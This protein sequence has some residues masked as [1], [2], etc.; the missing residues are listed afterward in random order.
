[1]ACWALFQRIRTKTAEPLQLNLNR[2][3]FKATTAPPLPHPSPAIEIQAPSESGDFILDANGKFHHCDAL[4]FDPA[5]Q[6]LRGNSSAGS[7]SLTITSGGGGV[8]SPHGYIRG[9]ASLSR[10]A[11]PDST[12][13]LPNPT[14]PA[15]KGVCDRTR[16]CKRG[17]QASKC[18]GERGKEGERERES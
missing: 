17:S 13:A 12:P 1:M 14:Q 9:N 15:I 11:S 4:N 7:L 8:T 16:E 3:T 18:M 6:K 5:Y 10:K 2:L